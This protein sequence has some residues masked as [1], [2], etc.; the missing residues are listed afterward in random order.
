MIP[1]GALHLA[2]SH[3]NSG[4]AS[5]PTGYKYS[6]DYGATWSRTETGDLL[7]GRTEAERY[8]RIVA[9]GFLA[10]ARRSGEDPDEEHHITI[11]DAIDTMG[12]AV[13]GMSLS[14]ARCH[15]HKFDPIPKEDYYAIYGI[16]ASSRFPY[17]GSDHKKYQRDLV[18]LLPADEAERIPK[19][20][21]E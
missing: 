8:E 20:F 13:L 4:D 19:P 17:A 6:L 14:C 12:K 2:W 1:G 3:G 18:P 11:D 9:T 15:D 21:D 7:G 16:L 10:L 5:S